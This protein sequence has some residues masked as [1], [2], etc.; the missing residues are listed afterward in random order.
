MNATARLCARRLGW[1]WRSCAS[2]EPKG[3]PGNLQAW[4]RDVRYRRLCAWRER[5]RAHRGRAYRERP[6]GDDPLSS[7]GLA[8]VGARCWG[9]AR[10]RVGWS[11]RCW[12]LPAQQTAAYCARGVSGGARTRVTSAT[13]YARGRV[14]NGLVE[15]LAAVH[16]AAEANVLRTAICC[17]RRPSCSTVSSR[18]RWKGVEH[19]D[20]AL[21]RAAGSA[22]AAG[23]RAP[24][25]ACRGHLRA[26]GGR[27]CGRALALGARGGRAELHVGGHVGA[28]IEDGLLSMVKLPPRR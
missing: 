17:V 9:W 20:R 6:G 24:G 4:A 13:T 2:A 26:A 27:A 12:E 18:M 10:A 23:G 15:A 19:S 21:G 16:P 28:V 1:S 8:R 22:C 7:G 5:G 25:G 11:V 14:R 3:A